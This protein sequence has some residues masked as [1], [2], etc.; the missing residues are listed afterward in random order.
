MAEIPTDEDL[1]ASTDVELFGELYQR[2]YPLLRGYL[3]RRLGGHPDLVL[4]LVAET[5]ARAFERREQFDPSRGAAILWLLAIANN[6]L[7]DAVRRGRVA[8]ESRRWLGTERIL[9]DDEQLELIDRQSES[10]LLLALGQLQ[11]E[12]REAVERRVIGEQSY[13]SIAAQLGCSEQVVRK[14]VS[15]ALSTLRRT[16]RETA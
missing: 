16:A 2:R 5:F 8:D 7:V 12:Q 15:R 1:L 9:V 13:A 3:R 4:D 11:P 10:D 6:L 14:R